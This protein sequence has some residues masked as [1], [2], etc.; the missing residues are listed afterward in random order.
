MGRKVGGVLR[1][2]T[3][4]RPPENGRGKTELN[5]SRNSPTRG[6][7]GVT[8]VSGVHLSPADQRASR[9]GQICIVSITAPVPLCNKKMQENPPSGG[10]PFPVCQAES[11]KKIDEARK[12]PVK[13]SVKEADNASISI[14]D[15][16]GKKTVL[17]GSAKDMK[18]SGDKAKQEGN[19]VETNPATEKI[20]S[21]SKG[22]AVSI[23][24][25][26]TILTLKLE[27]QRRRPLESHMR[28]MA[29]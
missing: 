28:I 8:E 18:A 1:E 14:I 26:V 2:R 29:S 23:E 24:I 21:D 9:A 11:F 10:H 13:F 6:L 15:K 16:N 4:R 20:T 19:E 25:T 12:S 7:V 17:E 27:R 5:K 3:H 22:K